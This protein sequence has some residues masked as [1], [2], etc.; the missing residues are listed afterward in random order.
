MSSNDTAGSAESTGTGA[1]PAPYVQLVPTV[2]PTVADAISDML[3]DAILGGRFPPGSRLVEANLAREL[4]VSRGSV[5]EGLAV[6]RKASLSRTRV[7]G[8]SSSRS[9]TPRSMRS[10]AYVASWSR[11]RLHGSSKA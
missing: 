2:T 1:V 7:T 3:R 8:N 5:R 11:L 9:T 10:T 4:Q 6:L